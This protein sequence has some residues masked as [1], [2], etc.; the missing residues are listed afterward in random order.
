MG[1]IV[2]TQRTSSSRRFFAALDRVEFTGYA[3]SIQ[4][5]GMATW[6]PSRY[7][8]TRKACQIAL[9]PV[10]QLRPREA[11][12]EHHVQ[13]RVIDASFRHSTRLGVCGFCGGRGQGAE[14]WRVLERVRG[15]TAPQVRVFQRAADRILGR[16]IQH[17]VWRAGWS[18]RRSRLALRTVWHACPHVYLWR[19]GWHDGCGISAAQPFVRESRR[20][21]QVRSLFNEHK[22]QAIK[23]C[24]C[25]DGEESPS[26][27]GVHRQRRSD[28]SHEDRNAMHTGDL[29]RQ[30]AFWSD[31]QP[32]QWQFSPSSR[33]LPV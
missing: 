17:V 8:P 21:V 1:Y 12:V 22:P 10:A 27:R 33:A 13:R 3:A 9:L 4:R 6:L 32:C 31:N 18:L 20:R 5:S 23:R 7:F 28:S 29:V 24:D 19:V 16:G 14:R 11:T 30:R 26:G 25:D 2:V 15:R